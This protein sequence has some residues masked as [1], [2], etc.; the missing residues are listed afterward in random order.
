[1]WTIHDIPL[2]DRYGHT[3]EHPNFT[4]DIEDNY[5]STLPP[6]ARQKATAMQYAEAWHMDWR[7]VLSMPYDEFFEAMLITKA[8]NY[9]Q[10]WWTGQTGESAYV[11]EKSSHRRLTK[12]RRRKV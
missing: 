12:P 1:M 10:P 8:I 3:Q 4:L 7:E 9:K 5:V 11:L 2:M 6:E